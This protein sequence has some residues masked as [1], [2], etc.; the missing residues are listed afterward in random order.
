[1]YLPL[2]DYRN[3][4]LEPSYYD[5]DILDDADKGKNVYNDF[6]FRQYKFITLSKT[7]F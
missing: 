1:M 2:D 6:N 4:E 5:Y 7:R 3:P